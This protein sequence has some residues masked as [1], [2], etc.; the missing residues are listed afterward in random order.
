MSTL[1]HCT[2]FGVGCTGS[3][4]TVHLLLKDFLVH[5]LPIEWHQATHSVEHALPASLWQPRNLTSV[6]MVSECAACDW[7][8]EL[9]CFCRCIVTKSSYTETEDFTKAD[10]VFDCIGDKGDERFTFA[11]MVSDKLTR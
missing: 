4:Q 1:R 2:S 5:L 7:Q 11:D 9:C 6:F 10:A 3:L 8:S